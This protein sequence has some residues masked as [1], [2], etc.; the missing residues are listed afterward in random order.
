M[1]THIL[2]S[3]LF[4]YSSFLLAQESKPIEIGFTNTIYSEILNEE[5]EYFI[6]LPNELKTNPETIQNYPV[7]YVLDAEHYF[8]PFV[9]HLESLSS[10]HMLIPRMIVIGIPNTNRWRDLAPTTTPPN[11]PYLPEFITSQA[12]GG[13]KF[14]DFVEK[15]LIPE[16]EKNYPAAISHRTLIGHSLGGILALHTFINR[17][18]LFDNYIATDPAVWWN[19]QYLIDEFKEKPIDS[20]FSKKSLFIGNANYI[21]GYEKRQ[22]SIAEDYPEGSMEA[23]TKLAAVI[24]D[25]FGDQIRLKIKEYP[26]EN[27]MT[28]VHIGQYEGIRFLYDYFNLPTFLPSSVE[29]FEDGFLQDYTEQFENLSY[30]AGAEIKPYEDNLGVIGFFLMSMNLIEEAEA[31]YKINT[32]NFPESYQAWN[33]L[34]DCYAAQGEMEKAKKAYE[35]SVALNKE[36]PAREKLQE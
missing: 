36:S 23:K 6:Y 5:R 26:D 8:I 12:G 1:K 3:L 11:P 25:R 13:D 17:T 21:T 20:R 27:H 32:R 10:A 4:I 24:Q 7:T 18:D 14:L 30:H 33:A 16:I 9:G 31:L 15:E 19:D 35:K 34:G 28:V 2:L 22:G 29:N